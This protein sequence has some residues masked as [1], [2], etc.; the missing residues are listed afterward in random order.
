M[1]KRTE[2][3]LDEAVCMGD[4]GSPRYREDGSYTGPKT[5]LVTNYA[6][7]EER[8]NSEHIKKFTSM[9]KSAP[10][11]NLDNALK[12]RPF[13]EAVCECFESSER[14]NSERSETK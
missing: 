14:E 3:R 7:E 6:L 4:L 2:K 9:R 1:I 10:S 8:E 13:E 5:L 11:Y 12:S